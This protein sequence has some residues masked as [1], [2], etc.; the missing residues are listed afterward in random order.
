MKKLVRDLIPT[1]IENAG[2]NPQYFIASPDEYKDYLK[3]KLIEEVHE[4]IE[5]EEIDELADILEVF[6]AIYKSYGISHEKLLE[7]KNRKQ[8]E[9]GGFTNR[10]ILQIK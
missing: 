3:E 10:Y 7:I 2:G 5:S 1:I 9:R 8:K 6:E 4:F